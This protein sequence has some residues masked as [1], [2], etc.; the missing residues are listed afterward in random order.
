VDQNRT[1]QSEPLPD[2]PL[3]ERAI[4]RKYGIRE[5]VWPDID[6]VKAL[7]RFLKS[8]VETGKCGAVP[9]TAIVVM[10]DFLQGTLNRQNI[11]KAPR[12][13]PEEFD[14]LEA[15]YYLAARIITKVARDRHDEA[16]SK[17]KVYQATHI[18]LFKFIDVLRALLDP[19]CQWVRFKAI[20]S[21]T[22]EI[23]AA[24][25]EFAQIF[26]EQR[27]KGRAM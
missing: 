15:P 13:S 14:T 7:V 11:T 18:T 25:T 24:L 10:H 5:L 27:R 26:P 1:L 6:Q 23:M 8:A 2:L 4:A 19:A 16:V 12:M 22:L 17:G 20:P 3:D 21:D 9:K